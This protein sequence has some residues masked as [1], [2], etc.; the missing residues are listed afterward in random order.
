MAQI[1]VVD[2]NET[3][4]EFILNMF[5]RSDP[6]KR[7]TIISAVNGRD[8]QE[9]ISESA[10]PIDLVITD[11]DMP[12]MNGVEL[13]RWIRAKHPEIKTILMSSNDLSYF[14]L[15]DAFVLKPEGFD[16]FLDTCS[17]VLA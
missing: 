5:L 11:F 9:K 15:V 14:S 2:D 13:I 8:A 1:L 17:R 10:L 4:R 3:V 12:I 16:N 6:E 7:H